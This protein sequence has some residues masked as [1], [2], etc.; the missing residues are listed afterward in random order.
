MINITE[1]TFK[2]Y[3]LAVML[4]VPIGE[5]ITELFQNPFASQPIIIS[6]AGIIGVILVFLHFFLNRERKFLN[7]KTDVFYLLLFFFMI[8]SLIF[9]RDLDNTLHSYLNGFYM[10]ET[11]FHFAAYYSLFFAATMIS[12]YKDKLKI[13]IAYL[14]VALLQGVIGVFQSLG[15]R[16]TDCVF[17]ADLHK[18]GNL[19]FGLTEHQNWFAGLSILLVGCCI[20]VFVFYDSL[21]KQVPT[22]ITAKLYHAGQIAILILLV[23]IFYCSICTSARIAW[24]GNI[25]LILFYYVSFAIVYKNSEDKVLIKKYFVRLLIATGLIIVVFIWILFSRDMIIS[26][27]NKTSDEINEGSSQLGSLRG[28]IWKSGLNVVPRYPLT[29]I[30]LDNY[31][32]CFYHN[33][34]PLWLEKNDYYVQWKGHNEYIHTLVTE[35][36]PALI[37]Y[38]ALLFYAAY[39]AIKK[40][41]SNDD[42]EQRAITWILFSMF[43]G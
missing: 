25:A 4:L 11:P 36:I 3:I 18:E 34:D 10:N 26:E 42:F 8:I 28:Y 7:K 21:I 20:G 2:I 27:I 22:K 19:V 17:D 1:K 5:L 40:V 23:I 14:G 6:F 38:L 33:T 15:Y 43:T 16:I 41:L 29:G 24:V 31:I 12:D 9:S 39:S 37:N 32:W 30:G 35:G 13:I